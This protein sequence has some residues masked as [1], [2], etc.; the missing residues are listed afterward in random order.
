M[1]PTDPS[2]AAPA[3]TSPPAPTSGQP[4]QGESY[5][6][7]KYDSLVNSAEYKEGKQLRDLYVGQRKEDGTNPLV[8]H[9]KTFFQSEPSPPQPAFDPSLEFD[10][11]D[12]SNPNSPTGQ[13]FNQRVQ[14]VAGSLVDQKLQKLEDAQQ[15]QS[16]EQYLT[17]QKGYTTDQAKAY[18]DALMNPSPQFVQEFLMGR[19]AEAFVAQGPQPEGAPPAGPGPPPV[20]PTGPVQGAQPATP[21]E[22]DA[23]FN[24]IDAATGGPLPLK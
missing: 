13:F 3:P 24:R 11:N 4:A 23:F 22:A 19:A 9:T 12:L 8:D 16:Y 15:R 1:E 21:S 2:S 20:P 18:V 10:A 7:G 5:W 6:Q 14:E 17:T